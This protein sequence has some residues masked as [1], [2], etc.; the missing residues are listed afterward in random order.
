MIDCI[1]FPN[2]FLQTILFFAIFRSKPV[3]SRLKMS[4]AFKG[5]SELVSHLAIASLR[6]LKNSLMRVIFVC[7]CLACSNGWQRRCDNSCR[8][9]KSVI[10]LF[11]ALNEGIPQLAD[12]FTADKSSCVR[13]TARLQLAMYRQKRAS[14]NSTS[15]GRVHCEP[16]FFFLYRRAIRSERGVTLQL[17]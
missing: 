11:D 2:A 6:T 17:Q 12:Y 1:L 10:Q 15:C 16:L 13:S 3:S 4:S 14:F 7:A 8:A 9:M 5:S